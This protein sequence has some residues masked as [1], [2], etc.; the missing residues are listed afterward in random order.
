VAAVAAGILALAAV[1]A[2][3]VLV[4]DGREPDVVEIEMSTTAQPR[5]TA[6]AEPQPTSTPAPP[7]GTG[8]APPAATGAPL[9][10]TQV[11]LPQF[12]V[13]P[14]DAPLGISQLWY[15]G[16][17]FMAMIGG[18]L[19]WSS[20][21]TTWYLVPLPEGQVWIGARSVYDDGTVWGL[22]IDDPSE[23]DA[24]EVR[25]ALVRI[26]GQGATVQHYELSRPDPDERW[27]TGV[28]GAT[29][30]AVRGEMVLL[31]RSARLG[32]DYA[33]VLQASGL[34]RASEQVC[35]A[36]PEGEAIAVD[37]V[38]G[39]DPRACGDGSP[40]RRI[41]ITAS[42]LVGVPDG[43]FEREL[44]QLSSSAPV[45][46][47]H[48]TEVFRSVDGS[49]FERV[50]LGDGFMVS[51][52]RTADGFGM[53]LGGPSDTR[54]V[55]SLDG[56]TWTETATWDRR[57]D[58]APPPVQV[59][60]T[61]VVWDVASTADGRYEVRRHAGEAI[62][63]LA[64]LPAD[65]GQLG[66]I[67]AGPGGLLVAVATNVPVLE[68]RIERDGKV[69]VST[70]PGFRV[71]DGGVVL[72]DTTAGDPARQL[73][74]GS[75]ELV[76]GETGDVVVTLGQG[77]VAE[78]NGQMVEQ[79]ADGAGDVRRSYG[80]TPDGVEWTWFDPDDVFGAAGSPAV[81]DDA[82][83]VGWSDSPGTGESGL[84]RAPIP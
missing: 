44:E 18:Q 76:D 49:P 51:V 30:L 17:V 67:S 2:A 9:E 36:V 75:I 66:P 35:L 59:P 24:L 84:W 22:T 82:V 33:E 4:G 48:I 46:E 28:R 54:R 7:D 3:L 74:D 69:I 53:L 39:L 1:S 68:G 42:D 56:V 62:D 26:D 63:R 16:G 47:R 52:E 13:S 12:P 37:L 61:D 6:T 27:L 14:G 64:D 38:E 79:S 50:W 29:E 19:H 5:P 72:V 23:V 21:A 81:G 43:E 60:G 34:M 41:V 77:D 20:D 78:L 40:Q 31:A 70:E 58:G 57:W 15:E 71:L 80:F 73:P 10:W 45:E 55:A 32:L 65:I 83:L 25:R 11:E 8:P